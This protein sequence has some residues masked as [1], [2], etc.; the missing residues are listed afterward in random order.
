MDAALGQPVNTFVIT[1]RECTRAVAEHRLMAADGGAAPSTSSIVS[2]S[3]WSGAAAAGAATGVSSASTSGTNSVGLQAGE[4]AGAGPSSQQLQQTQDWGR[5]GQQGQRQQGQAT[6]RPHWLVVRV[7]RG[8][9]RQARLLPVRVRNVW[10]A[11]DMELRIAALQ[12]MA[13]RARPKPR[14]EQHTPAGTAALLV[15]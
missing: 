2:T 7:A 1:A 15:A 12:W 8:V 11:A 3:S 4:G 10:E 5:Q 14:T 6:A 9:L 13:W